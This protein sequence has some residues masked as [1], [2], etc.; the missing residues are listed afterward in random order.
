M[1]QYYEQYINGVNLNSSETQDSNPNGE[2]GL[3]DRITNKD[4]LGR[5]LLV[6]ELG[7]FYTEYSKANSSPLYIGIF[8]RWGMGKS[9]LVEMLSEYI[10]NNNSNINEY[11]VCKVDCSVFDKKDQLWVRILNQLIDKIS[12]DKDKEDKFNFKWKFISFKTRFFARNF[13]EWLKS[14]NRWI[15]ILGIGGI[16]GFIIY[17]SMPLLMGENQN[18]RE[19]TF[20]ITIVTAFYTLVKSISSIFKENVFLTDNRSIDNTY[21]RSV[22]E[23]KL[24]LNL[25]NNVP[26]KR[27]LRYY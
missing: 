22:N 15:S 13:W 12:K 16:F 1:I 20:L 17:K 11:V 8:S 18:L 10:G 7:N 24:L 3:S 5:N 14:K 26:K 21:S 25:L 9:S 4:L 2:D 27:I 19:I 23:Y 6:R